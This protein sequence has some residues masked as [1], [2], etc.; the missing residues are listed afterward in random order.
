M[1]GI[2]G[3]FGTLEAPVTGSLLNMLDLIQ[4]RGPDASGVALFSSFPRPGAT[5]KEGT[6]LYLR[7]SLTEPADQ[8]VLEA[9]VAEYGR[10]EGASYGEGRY[11]YF[12]G[13]FVGCGKPASVEEI[14]EKINRVPGLYVHSLSPTLSVYKDGGNARTLG[15]RH[16]IDHE[17]INHGIG[18]VRMA[19]ESAED[20]NAAH[21]FVSHFWPDLAIVHNGQFTNYFKLRRRLETWGAVFATSNDS[22]V[23]SHL[24]AWHMKRT[25]GDL[26]GS[27]AAAGE[28]MDGVFCIIASTSEQV[29]IVK[30]DLGI[31]PLLAVEAHGAVLLGSE[32][33]EF[34]QLLPDVPAEELGPGEVRVWST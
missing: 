22:E 13:K 26:E 34:S 1:C 12:A 27:L 23:A 25:G 16:P 21:P 33:C 15:D 6:P 28:E 31:K 24:I 32:E 7:A 18:H 20:V 8:A 2:A 10:V 3:I 14:H 29:G 9:A 30:D 5:A 19:T 11:R 4:H 17:R